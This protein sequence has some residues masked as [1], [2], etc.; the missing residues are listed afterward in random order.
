MIHEFKN[1]LT[2]GKLGEEEVIKYFNKQEIEFV[3]VRNDKDYQSKD[4]DFVLYTSMDAWCVD[5]KTDNMISKTGNLFIETTSNK[6]LGKKGWLYASKADE[7]WYFDY[8]NKIIYVL[9]LEK[10]RDWFERYKDQFQERIV[11]NKHATGTYTSMGYLIPLTELDQLC[12]RYAMPRFIHL[13][14]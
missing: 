3:D 5:I 4:V 2:L 11:I 13:H 8:V 1:S 10:F 6:E 12:P 9:H 14:E 7:I